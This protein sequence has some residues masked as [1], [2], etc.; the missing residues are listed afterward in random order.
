MS[1]SP[2]QTKLQMSVTKLEDNFFFIAIFVASALNLMK[3]AK[4]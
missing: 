3:V 4:F 2:Y 1:D